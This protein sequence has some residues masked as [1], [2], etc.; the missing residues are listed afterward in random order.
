MPPTWWFQ[1]RAYFVFMLREFTSVFIAAYVILLLIL[2]YRLNAGRDAYES[3]LRF[4]ATPG[5]VA[6][7][8]IVLAAALF[9]AV[10]WFNLTPNVLV[11]R[12]GARRVPAPVIAGVNYAA[13]V[14]ISALVAWIVLRS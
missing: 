9:H 12:I 1:N 3:Y 8:V 4:L 6:F 7:H 5:M 2:L 10:T 14:V 11:V 13:W